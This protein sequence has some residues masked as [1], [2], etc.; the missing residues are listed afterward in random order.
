MPITSILGV[1]RRCTPLRPTCKERQAASVESAEWR[2]RE[3]SAPL[4]YFVLPIRQTDAPQ[5]GHLPFTMGL[6]FLVT[7]STGFAMAFSPC[8]SR[9]SPQRSSRSSF[10]RWFRGSHCPDPCRRHYTHRAPADRVP[11]AHPDNHRSSPGASNFRF[12]LQ[13]VRSRPS[14]GPRLLPPA[15]HGRS[16]KP[17][18]GSCSVQGY[19]PKKKGGVF[20]RRQQV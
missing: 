10:S 12:R 13:A 6:P 16:R 14:D 4:P 15:P 7:P 17:R 3:W 20:D 18:S 8:T 9:S 2:R 5:S 19:G 1:R 11:S